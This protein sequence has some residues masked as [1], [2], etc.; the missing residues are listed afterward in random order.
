MK[1]S[2]RWVVNIQGDVKG[3]SV[4]NDGRYALAMTTEGALLLDIDGRTER[5][6]GAASCCDIS[7]S[8]SSVC[9]ARE[10]RVTLGTVQ[11]ATIGALEFKD[12]ISS[13]LLLDDMVLVG[14]EVGGIYAFRIDGSFIWE[15]K[16]EGK[17]EMMTDDGTSSLLVYQSAKK[18]SMLDIRTGRVK[19]GAGTMT[20]VVAISAVSSGNSFVSTIDGRIIEFNPVGT[21]AWNPRISARIVTSDVSPNG[22]IVAISDGGS[23]QLYSEYKTIL[24][25]WDCGEANVLKLT[26]NGTYAFAGLA[27]GT[28]AFMDKEENLWS[29]HSADPIISGAM[30]PNGNRIVTGMSRKLMVFDNATLFEEHV[31]EI[32]QKLLVAKHFGAR[33][34]DAKAFAKNALD[35]VRIGEFSS[36]LTMLKSAESASFKVKELSKPA[37]SLIAAVAES[38]ALNQWTKAL[39]Y[40]MN[41]GSEHAADL[42]LVSLTE[43]IE[44]QWNVV[45]SLSVD[46]CIYVEF[47]IRPIRPN[48]SKVEF[49]VRFWDYAGKAFATKGAADI[50]VEDA[51]RPHPKP[52]AVFSIGEKSRVI[53]AV[54]K[55]I[56]K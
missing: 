51:K 27:N 5:N 50:R 13:C 17:V 49:E 15:A 36:A 20:S 21:V 45:P 54:K 35:K 33:I 4:S 40:V 38:F 29:Y 25:R 1:V 10:S 26:E 12:R 43:G 9:H 46:E 14:T 16:V 6:L 41:T 24:R 3:V 2:P 32:V 11:G 34:E 53:S 8:G 30:T 56:K 19:W 52:V 44:L 18:V 42:Q 55:G 47:G 48:V 22:K 37:I 7:P 39:T 28:L 31:H 23:V